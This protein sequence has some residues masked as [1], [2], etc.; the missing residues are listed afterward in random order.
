MLTDTAALPAN[1][2]MRDV[3]DPFLLVIGP[4]RVPLPV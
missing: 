3:R 1:V 2:R 4:P